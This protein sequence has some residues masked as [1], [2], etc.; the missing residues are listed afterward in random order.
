MRTRRG[1]GRM[2]DKR[3]REPH[4]AWEALEKMVFDDDIERVAV[5][6]DA[7]RLLDSQRSDGGGA[8]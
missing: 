5:L 7:R 8:R 2:N 3:R 6:S 1:N 4:E